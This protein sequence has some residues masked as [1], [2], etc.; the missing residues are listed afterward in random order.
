[1]VKVLL[2]ALINVLIRLVVV[3]LSYKY[4]TRRLWQNGKCDVV[5]R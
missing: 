4:E 3:K 5:P 2:N 1:M